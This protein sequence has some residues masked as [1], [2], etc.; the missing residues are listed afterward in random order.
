M[1]N[2]P[3]DTE[4]TRAMDIET[5]TVPFIEPIDGVLPDEAWFAERVTKFGSDMPAIADFELHEII[6]SDLVKFEDGW[7]ETGYRAIYKRKDASYG[8]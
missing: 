8:H 2:L 6:G 7:H 1:S 3:T 4:G 5:V